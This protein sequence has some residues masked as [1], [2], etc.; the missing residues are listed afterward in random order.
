MERGVIQRGDVSE[1]KPPT[2]GV[3]A[4]VRLQCRKGPFVRI[5]DENGSEA[6]AMKAAAKTPGPSEELNHARYLA[7]RRFGRA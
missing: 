2:T 5:D 4:L 6:G 1:L 7:R 3:V